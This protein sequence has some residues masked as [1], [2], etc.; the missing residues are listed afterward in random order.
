LA[1]I[2][3]VEHFGDGGEGLEVEVI[4]FFGD[5]EEEDEFYG[6]IINSIEIDAFF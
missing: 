1:D 3:V 2:A 5:D 4:V 6:H